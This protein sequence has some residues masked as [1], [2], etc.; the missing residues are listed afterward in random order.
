MEGILQHSLWCMIFLLLTLF[1]FTL[2]FLQNNREMVETFLSS[3]APKM[4]EFRAEHLYPREKKVRY[5]FGTLLLYRHDT[6]HRGT[7]L[8]D[9]SLRVVINMTFRKAEAEWISI[10]HTGWA[11]G[12]YRAQMPTEKLI[13]TC[14]PEQRTVLGFPKPGHKYWT[15]K[16]LL[17]RLFSRNVSC[18]R[19]SLALVSLILPIKCISYIGGCRAIWT[20]RF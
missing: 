20:V 8:L 15:K 11:W 12:M 19:S 16:T 5:K 14:T 4:A 3:V 10:V 6:W 18:E 17:V 9:N 2:R 7:P 13:A 1:I